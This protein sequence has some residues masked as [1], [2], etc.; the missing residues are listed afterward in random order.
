M[1]RKNQRYFTRGIVLALGVL[2]VWGCGGRANRNDNLS[3]ALPELPQADAQ[4]L[5]PVPHSHLLATS[6]VQLAPDTKTEKASVPP[7]PC[8]ADQ[9]ITYYTVEVSYRV[10]I[11]RSILPGGSDAVASFPVVREPRYKLSSSSLPLDAATERPPIPPFNLLC[12]AD[13]G[14]W[15]G[16]LS[17]ERTCIGTCSPVNALVLINTP[18]LIEVGWNGSIDALPPGFAYDSTPNE[19]SKTDLGSCHAPK[20]K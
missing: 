3:E 15:Q 1:S 6:F 9:S 16:A 13:S 4:K 7:P 17:S 8:P 12:S 10:T 18:N 5:K 14:P 2:W 19:T 20:R 11:C